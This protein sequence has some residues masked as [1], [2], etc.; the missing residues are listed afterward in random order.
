MSDY[1]KLD[2]D[3]LAQIEQATEAAN[4]YAVREGHPGGSTLYA[5]ALSS[6]TR[7]S[8]TDRDREC[9]EW[10]HFYPITDHTSDADRDRWDEAEANRVRWGEQRRQLAARNARDDADRLAAQVAAV[11]AR[12]DAELAALTEQLRE[13]YLSLPGGSEATFTVALPQMLE[14]HR[15]KLMTETGTAD[16]AALEAHRAAFKI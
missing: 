10:P 1:T 11:Q 5:V 12:R 15:R 4:A 14:D 13:R 2:P 16:D 8:P 9:P 3:R 6:L 7:T